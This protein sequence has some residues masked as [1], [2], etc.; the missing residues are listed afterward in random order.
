M[1]DLQAS[2][3]SILSDP[4]QMARV[5]ALA[6]SLGLKPPDQGSEYGVGAAIGRQPEASGGGMQN[7]KCNMQNEENTGADVHIGPPPSA[8]LPGFDGLDLPGLLSRLSSLNGS[9]DRVLNALR[10]SLSA[11]GQSR[12]D[13]ALRAAKLSRLAG[14]LLQ[15]G[16][17]EHV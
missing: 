5:A 3:Q 13:R 2:L 8:A 15:Q 9:E 14:S 7:A 16:R 12:V 6:E 17:A 10:P 4:E 11:A 1:E